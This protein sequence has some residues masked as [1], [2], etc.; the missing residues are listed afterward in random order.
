MVPNT[1]TLN[2]GI[3]HLAKRNWTWLAWSCLGLYA[4]SSV[5]TGANLP[6]ITSSF[7]L[8]PSAAGI[9]VSIPA[10]G[11]IA[12]GLLGGFLLKRIGL[13][14]LLAVSAPGLAL[15]LFIT[16]ISPSRAILFLGILCMGFCN[17]MLE[18]GSNGLIADIYRGYVARE[19]N[20]LHIFFST[21]ALL[22]PL[23]VAALLASKFSWRF[24]YF[25]AGFIA[26]SLASILAL[27]P[28][29]P[30]SK[31]DSTHEKEFTKL[32]FKPGIALVWFGVFL[33]VASELGFSNWVV[34][35]LRHKA[36]F[37]PVLASLGLS[38]FWL[39][40][41]LGRYI[42]TR[43]PRIG[44]DQYIIV[45]E[46]FG[47]SFF[48]LVLFYSQT[49]ELSILALGLV[50]F[51]MAGLFPWLLAHASERNPGYAGSISGFIQ[52]GVGMGM[53]VGPALIGVLA[54]A[55]NLSFSMGIT[56]I[57]VFSL[58]LIFI[59]PQKVAKMS[60]SGD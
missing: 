32:I 39:A 6:E 8:S 25:I 1:A 24:S 13:Q 37:S 36:D 53:L 29:P 22:S 17:G 3:T 40:M 45:L 43:L 50:G 4:W 34:T 27:R 19:L 20:R 28:K 55:A 59:W 21:G 26:A 46:A 30:L 44:K 10:V 47:S 60:S 49:K 11:F 5:L 52:T 56:A 18:I 12:A 2:E 14:L 42:N 16:A 15:S 9:L 35:Y 31:Y 51:F 23:V 33:F 7:D 41:L 38:V 48:L 54:Q 58:G 57:L